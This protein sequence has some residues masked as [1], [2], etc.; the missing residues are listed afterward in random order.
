MGEALTTPFGTLRSILSDNLFLFLT[1]KDRHHFESNTSPSSSPPFCTC[2]MEFARL[3]PCSLVTGLPIL[4]ALLIAMTKLS[5]RS[6]CNGVF[7][8][9]L[10]YLIRTLSFLTSKSVH[11]NSRLVDSMSCASVPS[12]SCPS[13]LASFNSAKRST[14]VSSKF[15][16]RSLSS[17]VKICTI[18]LFVVPCSLRYRTR[19]R[20]LIVSLVISA[21]SWLISILTSLMISSCIFNFVFFPF[22]FLNSTHRS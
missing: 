15:K 20:F 8:F 2:S 6:V 16:Y 11:P 13:W 21:Y 14:I 3:N 19:I 1:R 12:G 4:N 18:T 22:D 7:F 10:W 5:S 9:C 17:P